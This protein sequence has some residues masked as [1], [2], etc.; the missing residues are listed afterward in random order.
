MAACCY[1]CY[2]CCWRSIL[3]PAPFAVCLLLEWPRLVPPDLFALLAFLS[4]LMYDLRFVLE[5]TRL[6]WE[7]TVESITFELEVFYMYGCP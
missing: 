7:A 2:C 5:L 1:Y 6:S 3:L 4:S